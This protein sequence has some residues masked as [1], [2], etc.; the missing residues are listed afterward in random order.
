[1]C[2]LFTDPHA[3]ERHFHLTNRGDLETI[4]K[5]AVFVNETDN[6][7]RAAHKI[8]GYNPIQKS[9]AALKHV[10]KANDPRLQKIVVV[11]HEFLIPEGSPVL[12]G[13]PL[14]GSSSSHQAA[15][16]EGDL[17]LSEE[18]FGVFDQVSP[19]ED[20]SG[21]LGDPDLFE[22]DLLS[23]GTSSQAEMGP[24]RKPPT[25]LFDLI[26]G[27]PGKDAPGK[28]QSKLP[29][30]TLQPQPAQT[31]SSFAQLQPSSPRSRLPPPPQSNLPPRPE[32]ADPK[33][34]RAA[35]GKKSMDGGKSCSFQEEDEAPRA[36]KQL[37][38]G[39]HGQEKEVDAQPVP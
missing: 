1:M 3:F 30:S 9:I 38:I 25:N 37:K 22:A 21:D 36:S 24:K 35:K 33:R 20:P 39:H 31:R 16:A 11:E 28:S 29:P 27:Q 14:A 8:L 4:L 15:E 17:G 2:F 19:S 12:K 26:E 10:I 5:A 6:Q 13:I 23:V 18:E 32:P 7:V 34:K